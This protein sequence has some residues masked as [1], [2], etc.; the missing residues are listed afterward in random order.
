[1][2][3]FSSFFTGI[4]EFIKASYIEMTEKVTWPKYSELQSSSR[5]VLIASLLFA[6]VIGFIDFVF[7]AVLKWFYSSF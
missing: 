7:D 2:S 3:K 5:L 6:L 4:S 1:M